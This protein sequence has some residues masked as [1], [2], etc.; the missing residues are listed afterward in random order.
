[1][2]QKLKD[3]I[4]IFGKHMWSYITESFQTYL[5]IN[6]EADIFFIQISSSSNDKV[7]KTL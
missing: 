1:M 4:G 2:I 5:A 3:A 6:C 7:L